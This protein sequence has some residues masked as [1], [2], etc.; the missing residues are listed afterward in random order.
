MPAYLIARVDI[1]DRDRYQEYLD[2]VPAIITKFGGKVI[3]R[4]E[5]PVTFEGSD[6]SRRIILIQFSAM[7]KAREFYF[8]PEY[9][10]ARKLREDAA[11]GEMVVVDGL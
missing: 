6:E 4:S 3:A 8:S 10:E 11:T 7:E 2:I 9:Q 5:E 1:K